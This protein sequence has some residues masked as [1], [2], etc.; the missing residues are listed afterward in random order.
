MPPVWK[1][2]N[3]KST[4]NTVQEQPL[5]TRPAARDGSI[6]SGGY[7]QVGTWSSEENHLAVPTFE[8]VFVNHCFFSGSSKMPSASNRLRASSRAHVCMLC[9]I[10]TQ[11]SL[12]TSIVYREPTLCLA[13]SSIPPRRT[14]CCRRSRRTRCSPSPRSRTSRRASHPRASRRAGRSGLHA[15][16]RRRFVRRSRRAV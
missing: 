7:I 9:D 13:C 16:G 12:L 11:H 10:S 3:V 15:H 1:P 6:R 8:G 2:N 5:N 4:V 14:E